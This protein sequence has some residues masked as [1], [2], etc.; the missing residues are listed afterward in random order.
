MKNSYKWIV[1]LVSFQLT[2]CYGQNKEALKKAHEIEAVVMEN[3]HESVPTAAAGWTLTANINGKAWKATSMAPPLIANRIIGYYNE[4]AIGLPY[5]NNNL[6]AD[7]ITE[8]GEFKAAD[9]T[10]D[11]DVVFWVG[12]EGQM[13]ITKRESNWVEGI[14]NFTATSTSNNET[15]V[16]SDGFFR[17]KIQ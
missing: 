1:L 15:K 4:E 14:F 16:V 8:F 10:L 7:N 6:V 13:Q 9:L 3:G 5:G 17:I 2:S 12:R 11:D